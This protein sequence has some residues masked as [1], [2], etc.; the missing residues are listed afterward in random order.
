MEFPHG[1][2]TDSWRPP[3][4]PLTTCTPGRVRGTLPGVAVNRLARHEKSAMWFSRLRRD[5]GRTLLFHGHLK[6]VPARK[7]TPNYERRVGTLWH[8]TRT[9][10]LMREDVAR[11][12]ARG[13]GV[14]ARLPPQRTVAL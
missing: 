8:S 14:V 6:P 13:E 2:L 10:D 4:R 5:Q 3:S 7:R 1:A 11:R 12:R 9:D